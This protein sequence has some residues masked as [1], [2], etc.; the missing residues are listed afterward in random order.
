MCWGLGHGVPNDQFAISISENMNAYSTVYSSLDEYQKSGF[1]KFIGE[2]LL[3]HHLN[4]NGLN[5]NNSKIVDKLEVSILI[6]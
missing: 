1:T 3:T 5:W 6:K 2:E 4:T